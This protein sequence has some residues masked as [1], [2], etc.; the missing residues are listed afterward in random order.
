MGC[1]YQLTSPSGKSYIGIS[2]KT[3]ADRFLKHTEHALGKRQNG[4]LYS[5]LRKYKPE[6]FKVETLA[7]ANDWD[8]LADLEIKVIAAFGTRYPSGYNMTDGGEGVIGPRSDKT[9][10]AIS[11]AQK[12]R[13]QRPEER[14]KAK[15]AAAKGNA[16]N[17]AKHHANRVDGKAPWQILRK[18]NC[19]KN[20]SIE[21]KEKS[22]AAIKA[23]LA[24][25]E[26]AAKI[27]ACAQARSA[28]PNWRTKISASKTGKIISPLA[29]EHK[30]KISAARRQE[31]A[32]P[33]IRER[34]LA[35][36]AKARAAKVKK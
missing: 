15:I 11:I 2:S 27:K 36:L 25:P 24:T 32:N 17:T 34:R 33:V 1:L 14:A 21:H 30:A 5:A 28:D 16:V 3:A 31:W 23:A 6:N 9:K 4:V 26:I 7:I 13:F 29:K 8:Y 18:N 20:G 19:S 22:S 10:L 35:A 12:K